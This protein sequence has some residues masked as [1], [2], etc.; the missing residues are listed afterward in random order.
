LSILI[1]HK[2]R[3]RGKGVFPNGKIAFMFIFILG[4]ILFQTKISAQVIS[5]SGASISV[6]PGTSVDAKDI[7]NTSGLLDNDGSITLSG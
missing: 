7:E 1:K 6:S 5:N 3:N 4:N 2:S